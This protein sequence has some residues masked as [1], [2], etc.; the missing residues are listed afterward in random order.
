MDD[1]TKARRSRRCPSRENH[2][3]I[4]ALFEDLWS[5]NRRR[6]ALRTSAQSELLKQ[7]S[8]PRIVADSVVYRVA[9]PGAKGA[10]ALVVGLAEPLERAVRVLKICVDPGD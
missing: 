4:L 7:F 6:L 9:D 2:Q 3:R 10:C 5:A 1:I 8:K